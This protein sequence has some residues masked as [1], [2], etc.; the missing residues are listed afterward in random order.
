MSCITISDRTSGASAR[1]LTT[2]GFNCFD[3]TVPIAGK[4]VSV[5]DYEP[6]YEKGQKP[7]R[8]TG[9][10]LLFPFPNRIAQGRFRWNGQAYE[11]TKADAFGN[12][13]HG[14]VM[15]Q[16]WRI[17]DEKPESVTGEFHLHRD[18]PD[19]KKLWPADFRIRVTYRVAGPALRCEIEV[20]N[21]DQVPLPWGFGTHPYF[22]VP[23]VAGGQAADCLVD[24][25]ADEFWELDDCLPTGKRLPVSGSRDLRGGRELKGLKLDDV[26]TNV[27]VKNQA[28]LTRVIDPAAGL[29]ILQLSDRSFREMVVYT[30]PHG[31]SVCIEPYTC[32]TDAINLSAR[33]IDG[34]LQILPPGQQANLWIEIAVA[35]LMA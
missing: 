12:A 6:G 31:Q 24:V 26:L 33:E 29:Q 28:V 14:L 32:V 35:Q 1:I 10:P 4:P 13:I 21:P 8:G 16:P 19:R 23:L 7:P 34:G 22:K 9:I 2:A 30:P 27:T 5:L 11:L 3:F 15:D 18:A 20:R 25:P 17:V